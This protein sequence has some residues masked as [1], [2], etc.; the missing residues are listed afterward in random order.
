MMRDQCWLTRQDQM[1]M[2]PDVRLTSWDLTPDVRLTSWDLTPVL[3]C[4][5]EFY[6][7]HTLDWLSWVSVTIPHTGRSSVDPQ[8]IFKRFFSKFQSLD[9]TSN[10]P[11]TDFDL[12][13]LFK[14]ISLPLEHKQRFYF[15][16]WLYWFSF[17][18]SNFNLAVCF[19]MLYY[20]SL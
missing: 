5:L 14:V 10:H 15:L 11:G 19:F 16:K 7:S 3:T 20:S 9:Q 6:T 4:R 8:I 17:F 18:F 12:L 2:T 13:V 1:I